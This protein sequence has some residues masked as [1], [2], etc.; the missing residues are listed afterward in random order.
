MTTAGG[1]QMPIIFF[2]FFMLPSEKVFELNDLVRTFSVETR[3]GVYEDFGPLN[4]VR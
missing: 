1:C 4:T 2:V 3:I